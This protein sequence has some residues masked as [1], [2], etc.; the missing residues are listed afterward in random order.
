MPKCFGMFIVAVGLVFAF[1]LLGQQSPE[2][3]VDQ[4]AETQ[5]Q[6]ERQSGATSPSLPVRILE[7][8]EQS[9]DAKRQQREAEQREIKDLEA[10]QLAANSAYRAFLIGAAQTI[11][12]IV[13]TG[14]LIYSLYLNRLATNAAVAG[15]EAAR[16]T[17][18]DTRRIGEA[19]VRAYVA[20]TGASIKVYGDGGYHFSVN[21][22][23]SGQSPAIAVALKSR[24]D[25][26]TVTT[27]MGS[28]GK[29][30]PDRFVLRG[31]EEKQIIGNIGASSSLTG[32]SA[33]FYGS[34][35]TELQEHFIVCCR[36]ELRYQTVF[37]KSVKDDF[38][39][40]AYIIVA[41][42][43]RFRRFA[44]E[45]RTFPASVMVIDLDSYAGN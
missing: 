13:G 4:Q 42:F 45:A 3:P 11:I 9:E 41:N 29:P 35:L 1:P 24:D 43:E 7:E 19:Q 25:R 44:G 28:E 10:Q 36:I 30:E 33:G 34:V 38:E 16:D 18:N 21:I 17:V 39:R 6:Q 14:A 5:G 32:V 20:V 37:A 15:A 12:A 22:E 23:N 26:Q 40:D 27:V 8:P 31:D 2:Q